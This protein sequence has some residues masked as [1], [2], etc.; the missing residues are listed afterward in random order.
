MDGIM[1][2]LGFE[3]PDLSNPIIPFV[4]LNNNSLLLISPN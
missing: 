2:S 4:S 1:K 3:K